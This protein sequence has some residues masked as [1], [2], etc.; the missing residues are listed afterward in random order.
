MFGAKKLAPALLLFSLLFMP[1]NIHAQVNSPSFPACVNPQGTKIV[2][3]GTG[4]HGIPGDQNTYSGSDKVY[5][6]GNDNYMQCFCSVDGNGIQT[7]WWE[8]SALSGDQISIL[9]T[10]GWI[11]VP[12][13]AA[14]GLK[15]SPYLAKNAGFSCGG[16]G[17]GGN[18]QG[19]G[20]I[21]QVLGLAFTGNMGYIYA[22]SGMGLLLLTLGYFITRRK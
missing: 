8:A 22:F 15:D 21:G 16:T 17:G 1:K 9:K 20:V 4:T 19:A 2:D 18:V 3:I 12:T 6:L 5:A 10:E 14:W 13:G 7:N 11:E